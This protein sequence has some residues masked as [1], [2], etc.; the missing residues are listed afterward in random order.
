MGDHCRSQQLSDLYLLLQF[1]KDKIGKTQSEGRKQDI[2]IIEGPAKYGNQLQVF[3][4]DQ[5]AKS[6]QTELTEVGHPIHP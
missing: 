2:K 1:T 5:H 3:I 6:E 4:Q